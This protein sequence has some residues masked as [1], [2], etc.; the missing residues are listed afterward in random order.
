MGAGILAAIGGGLSEGSIGA[1]VS[2]SSKGVIYG[3]GAG[4]LSGI[5]A[6]GGRLGFRQAGG[7]D[8]PVGLAQSGDLPVAKSRTG[9]PIVSQDVADALE[10]GVF[11]QVTGPYQIYTEQEKQKELQVAARAKAEQAAR[12]M[13]VGLGGPPSHQIACNY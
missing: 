13:L 3:T 5:R 8:V 2:G 1:A 9:V 12:V 7:I 11:G 10:S 6:W 4:Y